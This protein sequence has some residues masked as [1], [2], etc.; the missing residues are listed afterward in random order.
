MA[1]RRRADLSFGNSE[2]HPTIVPPLERKMKHTVLIAIASEHV[3]MILKVFGR[4]GSII[5]QNF[6]GSLFG[7]ASDVSGAQSELGAALPSN[8]K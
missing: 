7:I 3:L 1:V 6:D 4:L 2:A 8:K 5:R